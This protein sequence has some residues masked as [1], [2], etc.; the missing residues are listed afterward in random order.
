M[1]WMGRLNS[2]PSDAATEASPPL[3]IARSA[4]PRDR[5]P[6]RTASH[7]RGRGGLQAFEAAP[8]SRKS[9][10]CCARQRRPF[11]I[12]RART[13]SARS[14]PPNRTCRG[15]TGRWP[16]W[17]E[18]SCRGARFS[19][20]DSVDGPLER[21][22]SGS[23][24][25]PPKVS[26]VAPALLGLGLVFPWEGGVARQAASQPLSRKLCLFVRQLR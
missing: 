24:V 20:S 16:T 3:V 14:G 10:S 18:P 4:K 11:S 8:R 2:R 17:W 19:E 25:G 22:K 12:L 9:G 5:A 21:S 23:R 6:C 26:I 1:S 13:E 15:E 7:Q